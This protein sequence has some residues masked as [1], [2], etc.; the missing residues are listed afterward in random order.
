MLTDADGDR[1]SAQV[2]ELTKKLEGKTT[3][4]TIH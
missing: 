2:R 4:R 1:L 3:A